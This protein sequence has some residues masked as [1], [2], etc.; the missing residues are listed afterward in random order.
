MGE[1]KNRNRERK[2]IPIQI[3]RTTVCFILTVAVKMSATK[4]MRITTQVV[5][6]ATNPTEQVLLLPLV[7]IVA[8]S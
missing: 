6:W 3:P 1:L 5:L 7:C 4:M 8:V 2:E